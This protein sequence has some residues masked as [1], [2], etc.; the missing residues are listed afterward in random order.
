MLYAPPEIRRDSN[1]SFPI[2]LELWGNG[3]VIPPKSLSV[4]IL[5]D[6]IDG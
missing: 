1:A 5:A 2:G 6:V 3:G 4:L